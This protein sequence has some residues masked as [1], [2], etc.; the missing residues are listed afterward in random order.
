M[1]DLK[2]ALGSESHVDLVL[3]F[4]TVVFEIFSVVHNMD[5]IFFVFPLPCTICDEK[6]KRK[7]LSKANPIVRC[8]STW[9][10]NNWKRLRPATTVMAAIILWDYER[11]SDFQRWLSTSKCQL[12]LVSADAQE[13]MMSLTDSL[14][15]LLLMVFW[16][17]SSQV[18]WLD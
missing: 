7:V 4:S 11:A 5:S 6:Q 9:K 18:Y 17:H 12:Y 13:M 8:Q 10:T 2:Y 16:I 15:K 14:S 1:R 3:D